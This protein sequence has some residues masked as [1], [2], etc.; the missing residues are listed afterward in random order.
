MQAIDQYYTEHQCADMW[1]SHIFSSRRV[2]L[3]NK[4]LERTRRIG[5]DFRMRESEYSLA[6]Q[7]SAVHTKYAHMAGF[8]GA[9]SCLYESMN[10][11]LPHNQQEGS[12]YQFSSKDQCNPTR[13]EH[14]VYGSMHHFFDLLER[15][16]RRPKEDMPLRLA[17]DEY[18]QTNAETVAR[19]IGRYY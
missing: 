4:M 9:G 6:W 16:Y 14:E 7:K 13:F 1:C 2:L 19:Q 5:V 12:Y 3:K 17:L 15:R 18:V 10:A 11:T 8:H